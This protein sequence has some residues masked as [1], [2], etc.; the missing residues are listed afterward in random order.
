M[1]FENLKPWNNYN[2]SHIPVQEFSLTRVW[3]RYIAGSGFSFSIF[4]WES[5][6]RWSLVET[7]TFQ[8]SGKQSV[9]W[10]C[11]SLQHKGHLL[12]KSGWKF[13]KLQ[14]SCYRYQAG[15]QRNFQYL[16]TFLGNFQYLETFLG[17]QNALR[18]VL[19]LVAASV[20]R[21][22]CWRQCL[23]MQCSIMGR[24]ARPFR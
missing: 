11:K 7:G 21:N 23:S 10:S 6:K 18:M 20:W 17:R 8:L 5:H 9:R 19:P 13:S 1:K 3:C 24:L 15:T 22:P 12:W 2:T 14:N 4:Y 16:E